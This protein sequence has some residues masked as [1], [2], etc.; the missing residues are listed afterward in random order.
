MVGGATSA[1]PPFPPS[2]LARGGGESRRESQWS[3]AESRVRVFLSELSKKPLFRLSLAT[4]S[5]AIGAGFASQPPWVVPRAS[6]AVLICCK[7]VLGCN[8]LLTQ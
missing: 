4:R 3:S 1:S 7:I 2:P 6:H 5:R 8:R